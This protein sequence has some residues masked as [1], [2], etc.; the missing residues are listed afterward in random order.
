MAGP[1]RTRVVASTT[2][3][4]GSILP[5]RAHLPAMIVLPVFIALLLAFSTLSVSET[6]AL[7][8]GIGGGSLLGASGVGVANP[9]ATPTAGTAAQRSLG[10]WT[11]TTGY[12]NG[13]GAV[14]CVDSAGYAYC[15]GGATGYGGSYATGTFTDAVYFAP[16][17]GDGIGVWTTTSSYPTPIAQGSCV[18]FS[19]YVYCIGG[20]TSSPSYNNPTS[21][22][23]YAPLG[24]SGVGSWVATTSFPGLIYGQDCVTSGSEVYCIAGNFDYGSSPA[25]FYASLSSDGV[26]TWSEA[27]PVPLPTV[28]VSCAASGGFAYCTLGSGEGNGTFYA[29]LSTAGV[30][31]WS[32]TIA[33]PWSNGLAVDAVTSDGYLFLIGGCVTPQPGCFTGGVYYTPTSGLGVGAWAAT[34]ALPVAS[35]DTCVTNG[36]LIYCLTE[37]P[38]GGHAYFT[39]P[40]TPSCPDLALNSAV[41]SLPVGSGPEA[42]AYDSANGN[43]YV[44]DSGSSNVSVINGATNT[45]VGSVRVG[46]DPRGIAVDP[47]DDYVYVA[48]AGS[49]NVSVIAGVNDSIVGSVPGIDDPGGVSFDTANGNVYVINGGAENLTVIDGATAA[50]VGS[51]TVGYEPQQDTYDPLNGFVYATLNVGAVAVNGTSDTVAGTIPTGMYPAGATVDTSTGQVLVA[52]TGSSDVTVINGSS[53][54]DVGSVP[55][56]GHPQGLA[57]DDGNGFVYVADQTTNNLTVINGTSDSTV[58]SIPVGT[59]PTAA[60]YDTANGCLYV[61]DS[62][63]ANVTVINTNPSLYSVA[64]SESGLPSATSWTTTLDGVSE[65]STTKKISFTEPNGTF[66]YSVSNADGGT[67]SGSITVSGATAGATIAFHKVAFSEKGL[68][69]GTDWNVTTNGDQVSSTSSEIVFYLTSGTYL[70]SAGAGP[71]YHTLVGSYAVSNAQKTVSLKFKEVTFAVVFKEKGLAKKTFWQV[72]FAGA[73]IVS[74]NTTITFDVVNGTYSFSVSASG[75]SASPASG[76]ITVQGAKV[77]KTIDFKLDVSRPGVPALLGSRW[78]AA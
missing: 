8:G 67:G 11:A 28:G 17:S 56:G 2:V 9:A 61:A 5:R 70:Y 21:S 49:G 59:S 30:G 26:G 66:D 40:P 14:S 36:G 23:Y 19:G 41:L 47:S 31:A 51:V 44:A 69:A 20:A 46:S 27:P 10:P 12:P 3:R 33:A 18:A 16:L 39:S 53:D 57:Y 45:I 38:G 62:G 34:Y 24:S 25:T 58:A 7:R 37:A 35:Y 32:S 72:T 43:V 63:S 6:G 73:T 78:A 15:V 4:E 22:V 50:S 64:F 1:K 65:E 76:S 77:S 75:Y 52:N 71:T 54:L 29:P 48:N 60:T 74:N 55:A 13:D 42:L 68:V